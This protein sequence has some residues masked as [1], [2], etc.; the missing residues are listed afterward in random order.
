[1]SLARLFAVI[2]LAVATPVLA[3]PIGLHVPEP[4]SA[5]LLMIGVALVGVSMRR[6]RRIP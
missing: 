2:V 4:E 5:S 6:R 1:M 3:H